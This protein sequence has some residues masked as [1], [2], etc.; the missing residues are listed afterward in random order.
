MSYHSSRY[1]VNAE[2]IHERPSR[3]VT[4]RK[5]S[6]HYIIKAHRGNA[7]RNQRPHTCSI[8]V[9]ASRCTQV[10]AD[11]VRHSSGLYII[12]AF[13]A[14]VINVTINIVINTV[15]ILVNNLAGEKSTQKSEARTGRE[16]TRW[17]GSNLTKEELASLRI[18]SK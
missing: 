17:S 1:N 6:S 13:V 5:T 16:Y 18:C 4:K 8:K 9:N 2:M 10:R 3:A 7:W 12:L 14:A 15:I 11:G